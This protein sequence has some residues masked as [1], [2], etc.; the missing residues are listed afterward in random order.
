M[1][2]QAGINGILNYWIASALDELH[3]IHVS[4][5]IL[6]PGKYSIAWALAAIFLGFTVISY[7]HDNWHVITMLN[8]VSGSTNFQGGSF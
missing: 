7:V 1:L 6:H 8:P 5:T 4:T 2:A 3:D